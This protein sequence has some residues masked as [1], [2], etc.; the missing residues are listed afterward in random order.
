MFS[1]DQK[2]WIILQFGK[3]PSPTAVRRNFLHHFKIRGRATI[4]YNVSS[5]ARV[6]KCFDETGSIRRIK[7]KAVKPKRTEEVCQEVENFY[8]ENP[9]CSL[10]KA[11]QQIS[12]TKSTLWRIVRHELRYR[13][14]RYTSVQPLTDAHKA[15]RR[16]FCEWILEQP[17]EIVDKIVWTDEKFFCL[18]QKPH[19][20]NDGVWARENPHNI[21]ETNDRNDIKVMIFVAIIK[22]M[23]PIVH[24]FLDND[25]NLSSVNGVSYLELLQDVVWP[26]LRG[27]ATRLALWWM[28]D[29]AP[30]HCT[31]AA[32]E[33][34]NE[35]FRGRVIS[36][37]T[38][39]P[40]PAH[41][42]DLNPLDFHFWAAAQARVYEEKPES[43]QNLVQCVQDFAEGYSQE[44]IHK[45][46]KNV[47]KR[48]T[49]CLQN[50]GGHFQHLM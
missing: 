26:R 24:S 49:I 22:G 14:Y 20:K 25:G 19:R 38:E 3:T 15:Q 32:L 44:T 6:L 42:P 10:R 46:C 21:C 23:V 39:T 37:R 33:F 27:S 1:D 30:P 34:L 7:G 5:F 17:S 28:Q 31:N 8:E 13:F 43:I 47:L 16:Q 9:N 29:G 40:W 2:K 11:V 50:E 12:P 48:A 4:K 35:K 18:H 36:R 41:S 45:V